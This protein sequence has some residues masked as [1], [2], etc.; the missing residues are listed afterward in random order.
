M[1]IFKF[2]NCNK[3]PEGIC[4]WVKLPMISHIIAICHLFWA[5]CW[6]SQAGAMP[7]QR[8]QERRWDRPRIRASLSSLNF[9]IFEI[10]FDG[11]FP[12]MSD[13]LRY[14][15]FN[16]FQRFHDF[17]YVLPM[18]FPLLF[19]CFFPDVPIF[20]GPKIGSFGSREFRCQVGGN[21]TDLTEVGPVLR[22][23]FRIP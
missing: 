15:L 9:C 17:S 6:A 14:F 10:S 8:W 13:F 21:E 7:P 23:I 16:D 12:L 11:R 2:A 4:G 3:L 18:F 19:H 20:S 5:C 1:A 22:W